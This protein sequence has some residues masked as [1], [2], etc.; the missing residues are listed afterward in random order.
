MSNINRATL[1]KIEDIKEM[2]RA[3]ISREEIISKKFNRSIKSYE[4]Y[5]IKFQEY[6]SEF[7]DY[8]KNIPQKNDLKIIGEKKSEKN[9]SDENGLV[10]VSAY[11]LQNMTLD[12]LKGLSARET[13]SMLILNAPELLM[14]L[15]KNKHLDKINDFIEKNENLEKIE[16][17]LVVPDEVLNLK[18]NVAKSV[19]IS[20]SI[21]DE[22]DKVV[23][24][25]P[26]TK[27]ALL[28]FALKEF[29]EK[30]RKK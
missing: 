10:D 7:E 20:R 2:M 25:T 17:I 6:F 21:E 16:N 3:K 1:K 23:A 26:Y 12:D 11:N 29:V 15:Q 27:S 14:T 8:L 30:Y 5:L 18:D 19:R 28:N 22:F 24:Q 13:L 9:I 4:E